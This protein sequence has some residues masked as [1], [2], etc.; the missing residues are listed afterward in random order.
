MIDMGWLFFM[1]LLGLTSGF[2]LGW[3]CHRDSI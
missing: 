3:V 2:V 1:G